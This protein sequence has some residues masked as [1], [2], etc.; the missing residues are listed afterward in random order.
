MDTTA[1]EIG[2]IPDSK[3]GNAEDQAGT[4]H[5]Q[6]FISAQK[7]R[8]SVWLGC[9][10]LAVLA[11]G[12]CG[13][14]LRGSF[15]SDCTVPVDSDDIGLVADVAD[16]PTIVSSSLVDNGTVAPP[17]LSAEEMEQWKI[18]NN[19]SIEIEGNPT[20]R[21]LESDGFKDGVPYIIR[22]K[23]PGGWSDAELSWDSSRRHPRASLEFYDPVAWELRRSGSYYRVHSLHPGSWF[24]AELSWDTE[25]PHPM[26][27]VEFWDP[28]DW[29]FVPK[30]GNSYRIKSKYPHSWYNAELSWD[31]GGSHPMVSVE[32]HDP[33]D[34]EVIPAFTVKAYWK[35]ER[36]LSGC[37]GCEE[38]VTVEWGT[39]Q[40]HGWSRSSTYSKTVS[41]SASLGIEVEGVGFSHT[42]SQEES[43]SITH[44]VEES[45]T[46]SYGV[47]T[48]KTYKASERAMALWQFYVETTSNHYAHRGQTTVTH[49]NAVEATG[50]RDQ[51]PK[52][53]PGYCKY[54]TACQI[55]TDSKGCIGACQSS[56]LPA[57]CQPDEYPSYCP[58]WKSRGYCSRTYV[59]WMN[60]Y[61]QHSCQCA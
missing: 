26:A 52:C 56:P 50:S 47:S 28:V 31:S 48:T 27:S 14:L 20:G 3:R 16:L 9:A 22:S 46:R 34:W 2:V 61:C 36:A 4:D 43:R 13:F 19:H 30:G 39:E 25:S 57:R 41:S 58:V 1:T 29:E 59:T 11:A 40:T 54:K 44:S 18:S 45:F 49:T 35:Y 6:C 60:T 15:E 10:S 7:K 51:A 24:R 17:D 53:L 38:S 5:R 32:Y 8:Y 23:Y 42:L 21:Q 33:V 37:E 12:T 55:C